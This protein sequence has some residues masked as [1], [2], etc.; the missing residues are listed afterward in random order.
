L[1]A[2]NSTLSDQLIT[3][4]ENAIG[5]KTETKD[6]LNSLEQAGKDSALRDF[7]D[8]GLWGYCA[9]NTT[10]NGDFNVDFCS[11]RRAEFY[12]NPVEVW[13]LDKGGLDT[14][15][16]DTL[17]KE[18]EVY[19]KVSK[20]MFIAYQ[21]AIGTTAIEL[22]IGLTAILSRLGSLAT[23]IVSAVCPK[24]P[25]ACY[26]YQTYSSSL[27]P[28][29][30]SLHRRLRSHC[31]RPL[32][33]PGRRLQHRPETLRSPLQSRN[34]NAGRYMDRGRLLAGQR[35]LLASQLVLLLRALPVPQQPAK[36]SRSWHRRRKGALHLRAR[37]QSVPGSRGRHSS[38]T[39]TGRAVAVS[40]SAGC[41]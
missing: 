3:L 15:L 4:A 17:T 31:H 27:P 23:S 28:G 7:Y 21:I 41:L 30:N 1:A 14:L 12:F 19:R 32:R 9:G 35:F 24:S 22:L 33:R 29:I 39:G 8:I 40:W 20:W 36:P 18:V 26:L 34:T 13:G 2:N 37:Q 6:L 10:S 5:N 11:P 25:P 38:G 16:P